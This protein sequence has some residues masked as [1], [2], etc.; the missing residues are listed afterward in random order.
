MASSVLYSTNLIS[1]RRN[2]TFSTKAWVL[3]VGSAMMIV[4]GYY[5]DLVV[6]G[7]ITL[8]W[9]CWFAHMAFFLYIVYELFVGLSFSCYN[10]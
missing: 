3:G 1:S 6:T 2:S 8:R 5:G 4:S 9:V 10:K 7:D